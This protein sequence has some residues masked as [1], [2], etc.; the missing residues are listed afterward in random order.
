MRLSIAR[1][2]LLGYLTMVLLIFATSG[3]GIYSLEKLNS[4]NNEI[5]RTD[6]PLI[7]TAGVP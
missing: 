6:I 1:K 4:N 7:E 3:F 5:L 2:L